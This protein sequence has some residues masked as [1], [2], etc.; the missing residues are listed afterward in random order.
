MLLMKIRT[1]L[2]GLEENQ[3]GLQEEFLS[4]LI[5]ITYSE[6]EAA[7]SS[8]V[9]EKKMFLI[10]YENYKNGDLIV[11]LH[12]KHIFCNNCLFT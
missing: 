11:R 10:C 2:D 8:A 9:G 1:V 12:C 7:I 5:V 4:N 6:T 3:D